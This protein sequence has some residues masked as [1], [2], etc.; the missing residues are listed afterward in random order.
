MSGPKRTASGTRMKGAIV[1]LVMSDAHIRS[2]FSEVLCASG[3]LVLEAPDW[4]TGISKTLKLRPDAVA[5]DVSLLAPG[6]TSAVRL[7]K[8][9]ARTSRMP[10]LALSD[11]TWRPSALRA[12]GF[13]GVLER[14]CSQHELV[15]AVRR[16]FEVGAV[17]LRRASS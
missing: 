15:E 5:L 17:A 10:L 13:D 4:M 9:H 7:L 16:V 2:R 14:P 11:R 6:A 12:M 1:M 3:Y 8:T